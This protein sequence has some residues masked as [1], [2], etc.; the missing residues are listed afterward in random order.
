MKPVLCRP[1]WLRS[2]EFLSFCADKDGFQDPNKPV[3]KQKSRFT[4]VW[5]EAAKAFLLCM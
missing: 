3:Y 2:Q 5:L 1:Q 4:D